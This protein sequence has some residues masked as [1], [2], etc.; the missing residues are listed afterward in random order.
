MTTEYLRDEA[1]ALGQAFLAG[2]QLAAGGW[3]YQVMG[4]Q[5]YAEPTCFSLLALAGSE[6]GEYGAAPAMTVNRAISWL[7]AQLDDA[8]V[9]RLLGE[10]EPHWGISPLLFTLLRLGQEGEE[11]Q[12]GLNWLLRW[13]SHANDPEM[14]SGTA[15]LVAWPWIGQ[16]VG[17]VE[18]TSYALLA[19]HLAGYGTHQRVQAGE[20]FLLDRVCVG[21][22]WNVGHRTALER[23]LE[24]FVSPTAL[25]V[26][27]LQAGADGAAAE[28]AVTQGLAFL[29][30][31]TLI[32]PSAMGLAWAILSLH[33]Y[34]QPTDAHLTQLM[35]RQRPD[36][37]WR[38]WI[39]TTALAVLALRAV[40]GDGNVFQL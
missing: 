19:L 10:D 11:T 2:Q 24:P 3:P 14:S 32:R 31:E 15:S 30:Q 22:G 23:P 34:G 13:E 17:W 1:V 6:W 28:T 35:S 26:L 9:M 33:A 39:A 16:T 18:P 21:G 25:A 38:Q 12:R 4:T 5:G 37:S 8:G 40:R 20:A 7:L 27:A 29:H 36:G